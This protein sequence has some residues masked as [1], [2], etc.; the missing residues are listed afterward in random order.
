[1]SPNSMA[2]QSELSAS[3]LYK[4]PLFGT[5]FLCSGT[6]GHGKIPL[7]SLIPGPFFPFFNQKPGSSRMWRDAHPSGLPFVSW[8]RHLSYLRSSFL[9][10]SLLHMLEIVCSSRT[11]ILPRHACVCVCVCV[12]RDSFVSPE[13]SFEAQFYAFV[14]CLCVTACRHVC[15]SV[16]KDNDGR[17]MKRKCRT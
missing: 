6:V 14:V 8:C 2:Y 7:R 15:G 11:S 17:N 1:M 12:C 4:R 10:V 9:C 16:F 5:C 13:I 3:I